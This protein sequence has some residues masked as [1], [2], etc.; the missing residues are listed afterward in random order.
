MSQNPAVGV[1]LI[2]TMRTMLPPNLTRHFYETRRTFLQ[3]V[4][5]QFT[6]WFQLSPLERQVVEGEMEICRQAIRQAEE[7]QDMLTSLDATRTAT[8]KAQAPSETAQASTDEVD[9]CDCPGCSAVAAVLA[10]F[11]KATQPRTEEEPF[12]GPLGD[13]MRPARTTVPGSLSDE[14]LDRMWERLKATVDQW[15]AAAEQ[16]VD[17]VE[18]PAV[19]ENVI[20]TFDLTPRWLTQADL[21]RRVN[22]PATRWFEALRKDVRA[23]QA[24]SADRV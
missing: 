14:E 11:E 19:P 10:F 4:G 12:L 18:H 20:W 3:S 17:V 15:A 8:E 16:R 13:D 9:P 7:E 5:Q 6:P 23:G 22:D 21:D 24:P 2:M 1:P